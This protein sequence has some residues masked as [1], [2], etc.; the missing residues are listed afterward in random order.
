VTKKTLINKEEFLEQN[1]WRHLFSF[2][3]LLP[4]WPYVMTLLSVDIQES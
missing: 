2:P 3:I 4:V 1:T